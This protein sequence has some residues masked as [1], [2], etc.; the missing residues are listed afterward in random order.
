M[1]WPCP[2]RFYRCFEQH[3][4]MVRAFYHFITLSSTSLYI[5]SEIS[6]IM[7]L[8]VIEH[9]LSRDLNQRSIKSRSFRYRRASGVQPLA[10]SRV[11]IEFRP[12]AVLG[13]A[14]LGKV[15]NQGWKIEAIGPVEDRKPLALVIK[16]RNILH[17]SDLACLS[18]AQACSFISWCCAKIILAKQVAKKGVSKEAAAV[19]SFSLR[20]AFHFLIKGAYRAA[21]S[22]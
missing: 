16:D 7:W 12:V 5:F 22:P 4:K 20:S 11:N 8:P 15:E 9:S 10:P 21:I 1:I 14:Q 2:K 17:F 18:L 19:A 3:L 13:F 6:V